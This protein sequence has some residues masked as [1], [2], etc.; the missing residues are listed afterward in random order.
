LR[1]TVRTDTIVGS[2]GDQHV[3]IVRMVLDQALDIAAPHLTRA[4][5]ARVG[6][7]R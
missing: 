6:T 4:L 3:G 7:A 2:R 1:H 5:A